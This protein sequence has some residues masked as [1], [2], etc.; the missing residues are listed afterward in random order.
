MEDLFVPYEIAEVAHKAGFSQPCLGYWSNWGTQEPFLISCEYG[1][2]IESCKIRR[3]NL[4][5]SAPTYHQIRLW[6]LT[7]HSINIKLTFK[8]EDELYMTTSKELGYIIE[9]IDQKAARE[10]KA[11]YMRS[12]NEGIAKAFE[13]I[14]QKIPETQEAADGSK[15]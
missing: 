10:N 12:L 5:F 11:R 8:I 6:F 1:N 2:E 7:K 14:G 3:K 9:R 4:L 15:F 13:K